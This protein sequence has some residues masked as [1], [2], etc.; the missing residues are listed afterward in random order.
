MSV[1]VE[2]LRVQI[3]EAIR[4]AF[5]EVTREEGVTLHE[6]VVIDDYGSKEE[7]AEARKLDVDHHWYDVPDAL[8]ESHCDTLCF[9]DTPGFRYYLPAYMTWTLRYAMTSDS[10][11]VDHAV[12]SLNPGT[13]SK[14]RDW[15]LERFEAFDE[16]QSKA[17]NQ[18]LWFVAEYLDEFA[19]G[20]A[21]VNA[22]NRYWHRFDEPRS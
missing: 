11:S 6:A 14:L 8:L 4:Q 16:A 13:D 18:F 10:F 1:D 7:R 9:V 3:I 21:A 12:Y 2:N 22:L 20:T 15:H 5:A 19:D 17:I